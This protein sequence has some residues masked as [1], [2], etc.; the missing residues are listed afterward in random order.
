MD[1][2]QGDRRGRANEETDLPLVGDEDGL[3]L[4]GG[5]AQVHKHDGGRRNGRGRHRVHDAAQ[6]AVIR[7]GLVGMKVRNLGYGQN[8]QQHEAHCGHNRQNTDS[9]AFPE[10]I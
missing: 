10:P 7:I 5:S 6:L 8:R 4:R 2:L 9:T 1:A 3:G